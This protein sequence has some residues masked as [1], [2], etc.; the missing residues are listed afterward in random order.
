MTNQIRNLIVISDTHCGCRLAICGKG[1]IQLDDGGYY[2][3]SAFQL[4]LNALWEEFWGE[5]V[6]QVVRGEPY[7]VVHNG[8]CID[9]DHHK[10]TTQ[11]SHNINDQINIAYNLLKP[12]V[13]KCE[14]R[15]YHIRGTEAHVGKSAE[16]EERLAKS[17]GAIPNELG[18]YARWDLWKRVGKNTLVHLLHHIGTTSSAAHETSAV[19]AELAAEYVEAARQRETPPDF[20]VR[21][22]RHRCIAVDMDSENGYAAAIVTPCWQ[23]KTP[24][25]WKIAGARLS[26]PQFGGIMIREGDEEHFYRRKVWFAKRSKEE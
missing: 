19:N 9:G 1:K 6:P 15:Y 18:Q 25:T 11:I 12:I 4:K 14:G 3:P 26:V 10:A 8:D 2:Q 24:Y 21:S 23:G 20:I 17:L 5:W 7:A 22:H 16:Y 13:E